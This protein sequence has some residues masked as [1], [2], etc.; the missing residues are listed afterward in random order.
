MPVADDPLVRM[1]GTQPADGVTLESAN[2][3]LNCHAGYDAAVEPGFNW[4]GSM[5]AHAARDPFF[6]AA[7]AVAAQDSIA[8][9]GNPNATDICLRCHMPKG[10]LE[11]R[12]DP[13]NATQMQSADF[14][15]VQCDFCHRNYD[16]F[17]IDTHSGAREGWDWVGYWDETNLSATPS[18]LAADQTLA[19]DRNESANLRQFDG[20]LMFGADG[21]PAE[22]GYVEAGGGQYFVAT[23]ADKRASFADASAR[24]RMLYSRF[25]KSRYFCA[26]CH[27]VSNPVLAN[28]LLE[29]DG[30]SLPTEQLPAYAYFHVERTFSEFM[31]SAYG[32]GEGAA[33]VGPYAP[34]VFITSQPGNLIA[35]CQDCHMRDV[36]G[37]GAD[38]SNSVLRPTGSVEHPKSGQPLHDLTGG[39]TLVPFILAST[40]AGSANYDPFN[41][42][43]LN[44]TA[45]LTMDLGAGLGINPQALLAG[46]ER[47]HQK[48]ERAAAI[49]QLVYDPATH[50]LGFRIKNQT[51]H[52]LIT[53]YPEGRRIWLNIRALDSAGSLL[54]E[55]NPWDEAAATLKGL[56]Y[57]YTD[58]YGEILPAPMP[59][60][61]GTEV[62]ADEL[63]YEIKPS[64]SITSEDTT[65]HFAL[66]DGRWKDNR[67]PPLGFDLAGAPARL[68][69]PVWQ[70]V[71]APEMFSNEEYAGGYREVRFAL[72]A[73]TAAVELSLH[74]QGVSREYVQFLRDEIDGR[75]NSLGEDN[76]IAATDPFFDRLRAWGPTIWQ[77]WRHNRQVPG[78]APVLM[79][80]ANWEGGAPDSDGDGIP[81]DVEGRYEVP[82]RDTDGDGIP[83]YLDLDSDGDGVPDAYEIGDPN[84]PRD[85]NGNGIPDYL[86]ADILAA[87][88]INYDGKL[89]VT[90]LLWLEQAL[91]GRRTL[92]ATQFSQADVY[93]PDG[94]GVLDARDLLTLQRI[95]TQ[96]N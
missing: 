72:P 37:A 3:C 38:K 94:D 31:L 67:I 74:Y 16:P 64:S 11:G 96:T 78:A 71:D 76:Y 20:Q 6:W 85:L 56:G 84:N 75:A 29:S 69:Q 32:R 55:V 9:L 60:S 19:A 36:V 2:R 92:N 44:R 79:A 41:A 89:T 86:E 25:H 66:A 53:G 83:D 48:L 24:H 4:Q 15:G 7:L 51:G 46:A 80:S 35:S 26:S 87:A 5:M 82:P 10:W 93:P 40:V 27:D 90:D 68:S 73:G 61:A 30:S 23:D 1:P 22:P 65:F 63:V 8:V 70:G 57:A 21:S 47:A 49:E 34:D 43:L 17:H 77:L 62:H 39:N 52:K 58:P 28:L 12:S 88:D 59:L 54:L 91:V 95:I 14:D 33:G 50:E 81:D 45:E 13:T 18:Q 42:T